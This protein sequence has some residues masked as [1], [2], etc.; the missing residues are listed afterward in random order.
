M[1]IGYFEPNKGGTQLLLELDK[2]TLRNII[3][4][5]NIPDFCRLCEEGEEL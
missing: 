4:V 5:K 1:I 3:G 2:E